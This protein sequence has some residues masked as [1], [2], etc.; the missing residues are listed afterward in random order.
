MKHTHFFF[1]PNAV[2]SRYNNPAMA[3]LIAQAAS[4]LTVAQ[5]RPLYWQ[6]QKLWNQNLYGMILGKRDVLSASTTHVHGYVENP[7]QYRNLRYTYV[8]R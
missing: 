4:K 6:W 1:A 5:R 8:T 2:I 7:D 3:T